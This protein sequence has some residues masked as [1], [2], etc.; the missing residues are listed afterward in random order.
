MQTEITPAEMDRIL[1][2]ARQSRGAAFGRMIL[3]LIRR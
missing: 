1:A 3:K 2:R